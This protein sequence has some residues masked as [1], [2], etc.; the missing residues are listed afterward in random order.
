MTDAANRIAPA[1]EELRPTRNE[2]RHGPEG[3]LLQEMSHGGR[4]CGEEADGRPVVV[5]V[6]KP[7]PW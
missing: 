3:N 2:P 6:E 4:S 1:Q 7:P 5:V